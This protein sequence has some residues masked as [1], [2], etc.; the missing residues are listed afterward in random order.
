[1]N[2]ASADL[3]IDIMIGA[4]GTPFTFILSP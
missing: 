4:Y 1:L 3:Q 2:Q